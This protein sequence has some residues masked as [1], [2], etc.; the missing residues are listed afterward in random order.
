MIT[1]VNI[2]EV[3]AKVAD[4]IPLGRTIVLANDAA[5]TVTIYYAIGDENGADLTPLT[6]TPLAPGSKDLFYAT[7]VQ[8]TV[9]A[10]L[11]S[12]GSVPLRIQTL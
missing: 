2:T 6:G 11:E 10:I 3:K 8:P 12:A 9:W 4:N 7:A 5:N 1:A